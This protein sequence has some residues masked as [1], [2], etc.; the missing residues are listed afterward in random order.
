M[1]KI[2]LTGHSRGLGAAIAEAFL[3]RGIAVLGISRGTNQTLATRYP[4]LLHQQAL[5]LANTEALADWIDGDALDRFLAKAS[6]PGL[7]N[8]AGL[9][10]PVGPPG[11]QGAQAIT[12]T[13][14][15]NVAAP[16]MLTDAFVRV[17]GDA[18]DRRILH[19]SS[20]AARSVLAGWSIYCATKA[21]LDHHAR[22]V[23]ADGIE[24][25]RIASLAPGVIDTDMQ[26]E[27]RASETKKFPLREQFQAMKDE[28]A[29]DPPETTAQRIVDYMTSAA[30][31]QLTDADLR[32]L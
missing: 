27:I 28:G 31:G 12:R 15:V 21:A 20:G 22:A 5:D 16:L 6:Q 4:D 10:R 2:V 24:G 18:P 9:V 13:V 1:R 7:I 17:T 26:T 11:G 3:A 19:M 23:V 14:N 25:L 32:R 30:F 8:N 29:L